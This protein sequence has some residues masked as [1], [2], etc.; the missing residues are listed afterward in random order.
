M[1][2]TSARLLKLLSLLQ[3]RR[4]WGGA[5][6]AE[7]LGVTDRSVRRDIERLRGLGYPVH[8]EAGVGG[9]YELGAGKELPPLP[10]DDEEAVAVA[11]GLRAAAAGPVK[12]AEAASLRAL[13]KLEQVL[14]KRLRRRVNA[15]QS[16]SVRLEDGGPTVDAQTLTVLANACRDSELVRFEYRSHDASATVRHVEPYRL[17]H[18]SYRWY[19]LAWDLERADWRTFRVDRIGVKPR[20]GQAFSPRALPAADVAAWVAK[21]VATRT[22]RT[23]ARVTVHAPAAE[24]SKRLTWIRGDVTPLDDVRC[25]LEFS[26]DG[27][28][29]LAVALVALGFEFEVQEPQ[30]LVA[31]LQSLKGRVG[32]AIARSR[33]ES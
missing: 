22:Q 21:S 12:G 1:V 9:G 24:V 17:V 4:F 31:E 27:L 10:L 7:T 2:Q 19:L 16:V 32:R 15:L 25:A 20:V 3:S 11:I 33:A 6:L 23:R 30:E 29:S 14:P 18:S 13:S 8:A 5:A 28:G 26:A